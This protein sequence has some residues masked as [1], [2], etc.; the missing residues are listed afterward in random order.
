MQSSY[1]LSIPTEHLPQ[2]WICSMLTKLAFHP[3]LNKTLSMCKDTQLRTFALLASHL[4]QVLLIHTEI[5]E[6]A[7]SWSADNQKW[8]TN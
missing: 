5:L 8:A 2:L 1:V 3:S 4:N 7:S 6:K